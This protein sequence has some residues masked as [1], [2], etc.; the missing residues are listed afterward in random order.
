MA[1]RPRHLLLGMLALGSGFFAS[2]GSRADDP[3]PAALAI[4][5]GRICTVAKGTLERGTILIQNGKI[6][7]VGENVAIPEGTPVLEF[8]TQTVLPGLVAAGTSLIEGS[9]ETRKSISPDLLAAD[10]FDFYADR[11]AIIAGGV[12][13]LGV[14]T[15]SSRL[16]SGRG[17][18][19]KS[20][21]YGDDPARRILRR[22]A[23]FNVTLGEASKRPPSLYEPP[24]LASPD[25]PFEPLELQPPVSRGGAF[26][27]LRD[28]LL[29]AR[30]YKEQV[31]RFRGGSGPAPPPD[32]EAAALLEVMEGRETL[33]VSAGQSHDML[34][35]L[36]FARDLKIGV[37]FEGAAEAYALAGQLAEAGAPVL[38]EGTFVPG[39]SAAEAARS[40]SGP[41]QGLA[42]RLAAAKVR[43]AIKSPGDQALPHLLLQAVEAVRQGLDLDLALRSVTL[44]PAE[45]L[46][47]A[48]RVGSLEPGKDAD[49][50][51]Y[52]EDPFRGPGLLQ[53]VYLGG[54]LVYPPA[55][56]FPED[57]TVIRCGRIFTVSRGEIAG[58]VIV[59]RQGKI[60]HAGPAGILGR[61]SRY[62][63]LID[64]SRET[65][66]PGLI[67]CGCQA[68]L[69]SDSLLPE[70]QGGGAPAGGGRSTYRVVEA[71]DPQDPQLEAVL[72]SGITTVILTPEPAG[73][74]SGQLTALKLAGRPREQAVLK[75]PAGL[76][77]ASVRPAELAK[78][79]D[80]HDK[81]AA[82]EKAQSEAAKGPSSKESPSKEPLPEP[83][84]Q[85]EEFDA[86]RPMFDRKLLA[87]VQVPAER[88]LT[89]VL[90]NLTD[91]FGAGTVIF[92]LEEFGD[93]T[94]EEIRRRNLGVLLGA[95]SV[96]RKSLQERVH[97]PKLLAERKIRFAFRSG[98]GP[99]SRQLPLQVAYAVREGWD[100]RE[101][102]RAMTLQAAQLFGIDQRVGSIEEGKD[103]DLVFL[104]SDPF[105]MSTRVVRVM[106][107]GEVR[108]GPEAE[109]SGKP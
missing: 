51:V 3:A 35:M 97:L 104:S 81:W 87:L 32:P 78:A 61:L 95:R 103:A 55:K 88:I 70:E 22:A 75:D 91:K 40:P 79:K 71:V 60:L 6:A 50:L 101:A 20:G 99:G 82:H 41:E 19:V 69:R 33:Q 43:L 11:R 37:V 90:A 105:E 98:T 21:G 59:L 54:E 80:Y 29:E 107:D 52:S 62:K 5:A 2:A 13:T 72:R 14:S 57:S 45:I 86:L 74:V 23:G 10:G 68:G 85:N 9:R 1:A 64:A 34:R 44:T 77:F 67:D 15:G 84:Q 26:M 89:E 27:A 108:F 16:L 42:A 58:G 49:L 39:S 102:L 8:P 12:T 47:V 94:L 38:I 56:E 7:A 18:V 36:E 83:P 31:E 100:G 46:G 28:L 24:V 4:R 106:V 66:I 76:L 65:V 96:W 17:L 92:G 25:Q 30:R 73:A 48:D 53:A 93:A 109:A 63:E